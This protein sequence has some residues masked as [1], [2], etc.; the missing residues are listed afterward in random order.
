M[1]LSDSIRSATAVDVDIRAGTLR[2]LMIASRFPNKNKQ[3]SRRK[4]K[5]R[6]KCCLEMCDFSDYIDCISVSND[7]RRSEKL[8]KKTSKESDW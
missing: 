4:M 7:A 2:N 6:R 1:G 5:E 3:F 8:V